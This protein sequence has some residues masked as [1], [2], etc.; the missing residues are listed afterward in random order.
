[1]TYLTCIFESNKSHFKQR[2]IFLQIWQWYLY[3]IFKVV[4]SWAVEISY[5]RNWQIS[6][7]NSY[8]DL[9]ELYVF[10]HEF[11]NI[12]YS[13]GL[14]VP[15][16]LWVQAVGEKGVEL[17]DRLTHSLYLIVG[18]HLSVAWGISRRI[19]RISRRIWRKSWV[20]RTNELIGR[21]ERRYSVLI[22]WR[23]TRLWR[24][25]ITVIFY[26]SD[27]GIDDPLTYLIIHQ[28]QHLLT[29]FSSAVVEHISYGL[30]SK[31]ASADS[32]QIQPLNMSSKT[33]T[34]HLI[35]LS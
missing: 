17:K 16:N 25:T 22:L 20:L 8:S 12:Y 9:V 6:K 4:I 1:M 3:I 35:D 30:I 7:R 32:Y 5:L 27:D 11:K 34:D 24:T 19:W 14:S 2:L 10:G 33:A 21:I 15:F 18:I 29:Y 26:I 23:S 28:I 31:L 13:C